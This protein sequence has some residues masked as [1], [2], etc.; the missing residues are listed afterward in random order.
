MPTEK[1]SAFVLPGPPK[2]ADPML[3]A[4]FTVQAVLGHSKAGITLDMY[5]DPS[6]RRRIKAA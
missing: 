5:A 2:G 4:V 6:E 1:T 3:K